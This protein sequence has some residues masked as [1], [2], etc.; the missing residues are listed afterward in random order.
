MSLYI[1]SSD[2]LSNFQLFVASLFLDW[3]WSVIKREARTNY[4]I[5][6]KVYNT[7]SIYVRNDVEW[8]VQICIKNENSE[9]LGGKSEKV[10][11]LKSTLLFSLS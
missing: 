1:L 7:P 6:A 5:L 2:I 4:A 3:R 8:S 10:K 11:S 9:S